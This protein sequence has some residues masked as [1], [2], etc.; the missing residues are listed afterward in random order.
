MARLS[1]L[2]KRRWVSLQTARKSR[3]L[4]ADWRLLTIGLVVVL[5]AHSAGYLL[6]ALALAGLLII[7]HGMGRLASDP[8]DLATGD[9]RRQPRHGILA[10][11]SGLFLI[12]SYLLLAGLTLDAT[13]NHQAHRVPILFLS[14]SAV[15]TWMAFWMLR[16][17]WNIVAVVA[18][19]SVALAA[20]WLA[21]WL[22]MAPMPTVGPSWTQ[23]SLRLL[24]VF[25][26]A[27]WAERLAHRSGPHRQRSIG[28]V[29]QFVQTLTFVVLLGGLYGFPT[30]ATFTTG[31]WITVVCLGGIASGTLLNAPLPAI[32]DLRWMGQLFRGRWSASGP[33]PIGIYVATA[34]VPAVALSGLTPASVWLAVYAF[35]GLA[36]TLKAVNHRLDKPAPKRKGTGPTKDGPVTKTLAA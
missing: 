24:L 14:A 30:G 9:V 6:S 12:S 10:F 33:V 36:A 20:G 16:Q 26:S 18:A 25:L 19:S 28:Q 2:L 15:Y 29:A 1:E 17:W 27:G 7:W 32:R 21:Y 22:A 3:R 34:F 13:V 4:P 8:R 11:T 35:G 31:W 5:V 23:C